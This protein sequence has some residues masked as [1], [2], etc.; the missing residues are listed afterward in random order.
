VS[1]LVLDG[2]MTLSW[3]LPD[4][5]N[6]QSREVRKL[7]EEGAQVLVPSLW[8]LEVA[9]GLLS[10][11]RRKRISQADSTAALEV[12]ARLPIETDAQT[13]RRAGHDT[14]ALARQHR[15]SVYDAAYL[16]L[17]T[18]EGAALASLD[19]LLRKAAEALK[20]PLLPVKL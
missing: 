18:R 9:N 20:V 7:I 12:L 10:A 2:S 16:E 14:L 6:D 19:E 11:E 13:G 4:E 17:A 1:K 8:G 15:L 3:F 5:D